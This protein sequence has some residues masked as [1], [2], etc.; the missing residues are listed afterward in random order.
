MPLPHRHK[1]R[2]LP[3][4]RLVQRHLGLAGAGKL[5]LTL[6][7]AHTA[8]IRQAGLGGGRGAAGACTRWGCPHGVHTPGGT[9]GGEG[10]SGGMH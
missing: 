5:G 6:Q 2:L 9:G 7:A 4:L 1:L 3:L 10:G 8:D